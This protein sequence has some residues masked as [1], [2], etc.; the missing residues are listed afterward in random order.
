MFIYIIYIYNICVH[1]IYTKYTKS[2][3]GNAKASKA[4]PLFFMTLLF[5][6]RQ[7]Y[8]QINYSREWQAQPYPYEQIANVI[9]ARAEI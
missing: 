4:Q 2:V 9:G 7:I 6:R 3:T 1:I 5:A 8:T